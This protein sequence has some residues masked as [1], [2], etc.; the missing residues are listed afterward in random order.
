MGIEERRERQKQQLKQAI[1]EAALKVA[2]KVG[3]E[4]VTI[5]KIAEKIEYS[6]PT[7]YE[8]FENKEHLINTL[9]KS[10]FS[11]LLNDLKNAN[12]AAEE[13]KQAF[14]KLCTLYWNFAWKQPEL[15]K[16]MHSTTDRHDQ[17][18]TAEAQAVFTLM[19]GITENAL[20]CKPSPPRNPKDALLSVWSLLHGLIILTLEGRIE[21]GQERAHQVLEQT[22]NDLL[23]TWCN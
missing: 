13:P 5:R 14:Q 18:D 10:G 19:Y 22:V 21:G 11:L 3:W 17:P 8:F 15:Y 4:G 1:L 16:V 20:Q 7:I 23:Q 12:L 2:S 6:P 9:A